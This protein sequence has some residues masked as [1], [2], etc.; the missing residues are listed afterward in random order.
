M[1]LLRVRLSLSLKKRSLAIKR[2]LITGGTGGI[3]RALIDR[4]AHQDDVSIVFTY[5][6]QEELAQKI[7]ASYPEN[8]VR[9]VPMNLL[10]VDTIHEGMKRALEYVEGFDV[11]I[12]NAGFCA[13][14]PFFF[15]SDE[16]WQDVLSAT[17]NG[18]Y[19]INKITLPF[20]I[21]NRSGRVIA[22]ASTSGETGNR[23]QV[24]Y[25]AAKGALIAG[26]KALSKEVAR[27][28]VLV[29]VVSPGLIQTEMIGDLPLDHILP[30]IPIGRVGKP[31]E[32]ASVVHFLASDAA[33]YV[34]GAVIRVN[35][36]LYT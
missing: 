19:H 32:V 26:A 7:S 2:I 36:G 13:D 5:N 15:M 33:S 29:N 25:S 23:G 17:L 12:H 30:M 18:F 8:K 20:M 28:G 27:K 14:T 22:I 11:V 3:G 6:K 1:Y 31:E 10:Q 24:N 16:Q 35:G 21:S 9:G 34:S 4:F